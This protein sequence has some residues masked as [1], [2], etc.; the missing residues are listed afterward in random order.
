MLIEIINYQDRWPLEYRSI[1]EAIRKAVGE[2]VQAI[3]HIGSTAVPGL[4]AKDI[5][6]VQLTVAELPAQSEASI[7]EVGF[8]LGASVADH[9]PTGTF[10]SADQLAKRFYTHAEPAAHIHVRQAGR[11]NQRYPLLCRDYLR[12][13]PSARDAYEEIKRQLAARFPQDKAVYYAVKDPVFD[14]I[15][16]GAEDWARQINWTIPPA[17]E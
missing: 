16:V 1:A 2:N 5:I 14:L 17:D 6:D 8:E 11:F 3:H 9:Y 13:H 10:L 12:A 4:A 7:G 15:I